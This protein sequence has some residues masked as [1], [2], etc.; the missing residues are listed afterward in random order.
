MQHSKCCNQD[1]NRQLLKTD[2]GIITFFSEKSGKD[3]AKL[4][5]AGVNL[6]ERVSHSRG[7]AP[8]AGKAKWKKAG[9]PKRTGPA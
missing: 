2:K 5:T 1:L 7:E 8:Q 9:N 6:E 3:S 4:H